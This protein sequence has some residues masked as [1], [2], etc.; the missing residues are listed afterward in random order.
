MVAGGGRRCTRGNIM[1]YGFQVNNGPVKWTDAESATYV[2]YEFERHGFQVKAPA[3][4]R[5]L[6]LTASQKLLVLDQ[7]TAPIWEEKAHG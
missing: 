3:Q 2:F 1:L 4:I 5:L 7:F 6:G